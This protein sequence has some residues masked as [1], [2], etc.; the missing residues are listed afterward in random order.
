MSRRTIN[1]DSISQS[2]WNLGGTRFYCSR[3]S[4]GTNAPGTAPATVAATTKQLPKL[5]VTVAVQESSGQDRENVEDLLMIELGNQPFLQVVDRQAIQAVM[6]EHAIALTNLGDAKNAACL[7]QVCRG[8]LPPAR[9]G[10]KENSGDPIGRGGYWPG[11]AGGTSRA[12]R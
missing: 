5:A 11:E 8:G 2:L 7:G 10:G 9:S 3:L 6:K 1:N 4:L 12:D